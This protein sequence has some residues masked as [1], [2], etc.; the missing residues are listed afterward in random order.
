MTDAER[1]NSARSKHQQ[2]CATLVEAYTDGAA[3]EPLAETVEP[4]TILFQTELT[5]ER[6]TVPSHSVSDL[7]SALTANL[8]DE[9]TAIDIYVRTR[10]TAA[11]LVEATYRTAV[12]REA[13]VRLH[14]ET[15][16]TY[17][18][19]I[20]TDTEEAAP[21][22]SVYTAAVQQFIDGVREE[23]DEQRTSE[24]RDE[25]YEQFSRWYRNL[26]DATGP[27]RPEFGNHL[28]AEGLEPPLR[29]AEATDGN[30]EVAT[31]E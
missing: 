21:S 10:E 1:T 20:P 11:R 28:A 22:P 23:P 31:E 18:R 3:T 26:T 27:S 19:Y 15:E 24:T 17:T 4:G 29:G 7:V 8:T 9:V 12:F 6:T 13:I 2:L 25:L 14:V 16:G 30:Y 5:T